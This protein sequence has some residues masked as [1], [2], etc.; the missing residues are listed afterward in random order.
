M[1]HIQMIYGYIRDKDVFEREYGLYLSRRLLSNSSSSDRMEQQ[2]IG[3]LKAECAYVWTQ[4]LEDM[5][6]DIQTSKEVMKE[7]VKIS[8]SQGNP[9]SFDLNMNI[10]EYGKWP[11]KMDREKMNKVVPPDQLQDVY[12]RLRDF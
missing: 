11:E 4:K 2:M 10:C 6:K 7:F 9:L 3:F 1:K 8:K 5:F 12:Q